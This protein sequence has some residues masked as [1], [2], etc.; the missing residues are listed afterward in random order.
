[1]EPYGSKVISLS[2]HFFIYCFHVHRNFDLTIAERHFII[3]AI[4]KKIGKN[5][6]FRKKKEFF[7]SRRKRLKPESDQH[8]SKAA[9]DNRRIYYIVSL[10]TFAR[11]F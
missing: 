4:S 5:V 3:L 8:C 10:L 2:S 6:K 9:Y 1:M 11:R 7:S